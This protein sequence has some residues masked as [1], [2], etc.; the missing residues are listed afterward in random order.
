MMSPSPLVHAPLYF[1]MVSTSSAELPNLSPNN[2][3]MLRPILIT[4]QGD[5]IPWWSSLT[6]NTVSTH[7]FFS[8][9]MWWCFV[10]CVTSCHMTG[11]VVV[12]NFKV[13]ACNFF[14]GYQ[15]NGENL[16]WSRRP[17]NSTHKQDMN[18]WQFYSCNGILTVQYRI[19]TVNIRYTELNNIQLHTKRYYNLKLIIIQDHTI[20]STNS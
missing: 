12:A 11:C 2:H 4:I 8:S 17:I 16:W 14:G 15:E 20:Y 13:Q 7:I 19:S 1:E 10:N 9:L 18:Q 3:L 6:T 5:H